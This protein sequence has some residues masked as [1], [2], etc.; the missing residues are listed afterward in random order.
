MSDEN[1]EFVNF[2]LDKAEKKEEVK[3]QK[4][5]SPEKDPEPEPQHQMTEEEMKE[6][7]NFTENL[8]K[9]MQE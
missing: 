7:E 1:E 2:M 3:P 9:K 6:V 5:L 8:K 4:M